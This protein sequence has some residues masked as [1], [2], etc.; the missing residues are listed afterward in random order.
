MPRRAQPSRTAYPRPHHR[1]QAPISRA[2]RPF[3]RLQH[4]SAPAPSLYGASGCAATPTDDELT[5]HGIVL[6]SHARSAVACHPILPT[7]QAGP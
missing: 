4:A 6:W 1:T 5:P 7:A 3:G 2:P